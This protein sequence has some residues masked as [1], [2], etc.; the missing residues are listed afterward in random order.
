[1]GHASLLHPHFFSFFLGVTS[2]AQTRANFNFNMDDLCYMPSSQT[3]YL[4]S[5]EDHEV[6]G[7]CI[8]HSIAKVMVTLVSKP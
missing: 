1:L 8:K 2:H 3:Q 5:Q 7:K 4:T 6:K